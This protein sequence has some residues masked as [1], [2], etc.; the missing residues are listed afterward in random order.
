MADIKQRKKVKNLFNPLQ[1]ELDKPLSRSFKESAGIAAIFAGPAKADKIKKTIKKTKDL[2]PRLRK[3][4]KHGDSPAVKRLQKDQLS[5]SRKLIDS[6][7]LQKAQR[8][9][10]RRAEQAKRSKEFANATPK[11]KK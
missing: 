8:S 11:D 4:F 7:V 10:N 9:S 1:G 2:I 3:L 6:K 5:K